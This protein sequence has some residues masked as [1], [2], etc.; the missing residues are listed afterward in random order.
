MLHYCY[1][2]YIKLKQI[3]CMLWQQQKLLEFPFREPF[4]SPLF[5]IHFFFI[6]EKLV[7]YYLFIYLLSKFKQIFLIS[8]YC[9]APQSTQ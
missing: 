3:L 2:G 6:F 4:L 7:N 1:V 9:S 8:P 5:L